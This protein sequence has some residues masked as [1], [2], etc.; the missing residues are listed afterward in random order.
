MAEIR[1]K[2]KHLHSL[3]QH[4]MGCMFQSEMQP[5]IF[6]FKHPKK[7]GI[8]TC[9]VQQSIDIAFLNEKNK[10]IELK[11]DMKPWQFYTS[12]S[13]PKYMVET[14]SKQFNLKLGDKV[15]FL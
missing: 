12:K 10:I 3:W 13:A 4:T 2:G 14:K 1:I 8:H 9:F 15:I 5:L 7:I 11:L 6:I